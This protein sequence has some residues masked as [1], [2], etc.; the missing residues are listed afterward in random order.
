[1]RFSVRRVFQAART[2]TG[3]KPWVRFSLGGWFW[4]GKGY[5]I[6]TQYLRPDPGGLLAVSSHEYGKL[7]SGAVWETLR[8]NLLES[9]EQNAADNPDQGSPMGESTGAQRGPLCSEYSGKWFWNYKRHALAPNRPGALG[10]KIC[11]CVSNRGIKESL[12][13][14][15]LASSYIDYRRISENLRLVDNMWNSPRN[16]AAMGDS[17]LLLRAHSGFSA[18]DRGFFPLVGCLLGRNHVHLPLQTWFWAIYQG[19]I[20]ETFY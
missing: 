17:I 4:C 7:S 8:R 1:M 18:E 20:L 3:W 9:F 16:A 10:I 12:K 5:K 15:S 14:L 2:S 6:E 19:Y 13:R 11:V